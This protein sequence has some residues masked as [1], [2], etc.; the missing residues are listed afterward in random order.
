MKPARTKRKPYIR[1]VSHGFTLIELIVSVAIFSLIML[2]VTGAYLSL[3]AA[4]HRAS[5]TSSV[6]TNVSTAVDSMARAIRTGT[7]YSCGG[8]G[9]CAPPSGGSQFSFIDDQGRTV[10]YLLANG[11]LARCVNIA[12]T[13]SSATPI[14]DPAVSISTLAFYV[15]G[16]ATYASGDTTQPNVIMVVKG[17][18][19]VQKSA[20]VT[21]SI[22]TSA[23]QRIPDIGT[24][25]TGGLGSNGAFASGG[26]IAESGGYTIHTFTS[27]GTF[28]PNT[29]GAVDV[30]VIGG[31]GGGGSGNS[32][33]C[34][35]GGGGG[36]GGF[37]YQSGVS[38][39]AKAYSVTVGGGGAGGSSGALNNGVSGSTSAFNSVTAAGGGGGG[40]GNCS[41]SGGNGSAGASGGGGGYGTNG[42]GA[43]TGGAGT[44]GQGHNGAASQTGGT[45]GGGGG[46]GGA[47]TTGIG[48]AG[49]SNSISGSAVTYAAGGQGNTNGLT[50]GVTSPPAPSNTG[51]GGA[52]GW[53]ATGG[54][55]G[56]GI[57]II[58]YPTP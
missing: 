20:P 3:I 33:T 8:A 54:N 45:S 39:T 2:F 14:T 29:S 50:S 28:T 53:S 32:T 13:P 36:A 41:G 40:Y 31:G 10:T 56:S 18:A 27:S 7:N 37:V 43:N 46:A 5:A 38:V 21:F 34:V 15:R 42:P 9:D 48:G 55:G 12:C 51:N 52:G 11:S 25:G 49:L 57:V 17:S 22:E 16:T 19:V 35:M 26:T 44:S 24:G 4:T 47:A 1:P 23:T 58:R 30:L 6:M